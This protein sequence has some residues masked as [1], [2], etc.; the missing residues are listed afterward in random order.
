M[1]WN[2]H[3]ALQHAKVRPEAATQESHKKQAQQK[4]A[5]QQAKW[6]GGCWPGVW[7]EQG[8]KQA[9]DSGSSQASQAGQSCTQWDLQIP[10]WPHGECVNPQVHLYQ[11]QCKGDIGNVQWWTDKKTRQ[12]SDSV[13]F[14]IHLSKEGVLSCKH[15]TQDVCMVN[16]VHK[17]HSMCKT[18]VCIYCCWDTME[19]I[20]LSIKIFY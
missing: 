14:A 13:K 8:G 15:G 20:L 11:R 12:L 4:L 17:Y 6:H 1:G 16:K 3:L 9:E 2:W 7:S 19:D 18:A 5:R 10:C